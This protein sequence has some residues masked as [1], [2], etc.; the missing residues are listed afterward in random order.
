MIPRVSITLV[1]LYGLSAFLARHTGVEYCL[2]GIRQSR[3][4]QRINDSAPHFLFIT[5]P[6]ESGNNRPT[7]RRI[8]NRCNRPCILT[9]SGHGS[10]IRS[11][12]GYGRWNCT[13][14]DEAASGLPRSWGSMIPRFDA[15][16]ES[17]RSTAWKACI[18]TVV[19]I[20]P[21]PRRDYP[22]MGRT[23]ESLRKRTRLTRKPGI[24]WHPSHV[25][26]G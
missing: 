5:I 24:Q 19:P 9:R 3:A 25:A 23:K 10:P 20:T 26:T 13:N 8:K 15:G 16:S 22:F 6:Q 18:L 2:S 17:T 12:S 14:K 11:P 21:R 4:P 7:T 1:T